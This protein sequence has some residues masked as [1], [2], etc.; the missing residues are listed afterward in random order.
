MKEIQ[1][2]SVW[3]D[4]QTQTATQL[5]LTIVYDNLETDAVFEYHLSDSENN[6][7][8]NGRLSIDGTDYANWGLST[9]ANGDAYIFAAA[10]LNLT[11]I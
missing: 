5:T 7:L 2:I 11:L 4:G 9:D 6:S 8:I 1:P 3:V 10:Q